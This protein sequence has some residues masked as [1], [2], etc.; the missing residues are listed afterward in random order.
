M[1][2]WSERLKEELCLLVD[3]AK[4]EGTAV[5]DIRKRLFGSYSPFKSQPVDHVTWVPLDDVT[6]NDYNPNRTAAPE[7]KLLRKSIEEDGVTQ[8]IVAAW[9][10]EKKKYVVVDG[11]HRW[12]V[13]KKFP[14]IAERT[15]GCV[16]IVVLDKSMNERM[17]ST[18]RHNRA[19]GRHTVD[20][21]SGLVFDM[22]AGGMADEAICNELGM[23]AEELLRLKH[24]TGFSKLYADH[25]YTDEWEVR[26]QVKLR[27]AWELKYGKKSTSAL[28]GKKKYVSNLKLSTEKA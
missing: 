6:A 19:R 15:H 4:D 2:A 9:D 16:P 11:F 26:S 7:M 22:L 21:M 10:D 8:P 20:G 24:L 13:F 25:D 1:G 18:V 12:L 3:K 23:E 5:R 27:L 28:R 14:E 17:A